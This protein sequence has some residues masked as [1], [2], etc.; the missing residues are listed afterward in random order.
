M[1]FV[2]VR[3]ATATTRS[4]PSARAA[5][6]RAAKRS[7]STAG[8]ITRTLSRGAPSSTTCRAMCSETT[9]TP[10]HR[11]RTRRSAVRRAGS[12]PGTTSSAEPRQL[13]RTRASP[14]SPRTGSHATAMPLKPKC[15]ASGRVA[16]TAAARA[17]TP[18][19]GL[20]PRPIPRASARARGSSW[21]R[22]QAARGR[23]GEARGGTGCATI[24]P[25][26]RPVAGRDRRSGSSVTAWPAT[27]RAATKDPMKVSDPPGRSFTT[28]VTRL[29]GPPPRRGRGWRWV[30]AHSWRARRFHRPRVRSTR[31]R[32]WSPYQ[33]RTASSSKTP[34]GKMSASEQVADQG[35]H[36][37]AQPSTERHGE[38]LLRPG[39]GRRVDAASEG[40]AQRPLALGAHRAPSPGRRARR[41][42]PGRGRGGGPAPPGSGTCWPGLP[43]A[44]SS[45]GGTPAR[46][47]AS[48]GGARRRRAPRRCR[49]A[50]PSAADRG[51][52]GRWRPGPRRGARSGRRGTSHRS[53]GR[54]C[55]EPVAE[56]SG[57]GLVRP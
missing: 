28:T 33:R 27:A 24:A 54:G 4:P 30:R 2:D 57:A 29:T 21:R 5:R 36:L 35:L 7:R 51:A 34:E 39:D 18:T 31:P 22:R 9:W 15:T 45:A 49:T 17:A 23:W 47:P 13:V 14:T 55:R 48:T 43:S 38:A 42:R 53:S 20:A 16:R 50:W 52:P 32:R 46:W 37:V 44:G 26:G 19:R 56:P 25:S 41:P 12:R 8:R 40:V 11:P 1:P 6:G 10:S 3:R